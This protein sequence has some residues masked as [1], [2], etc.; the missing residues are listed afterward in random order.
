VHIEPTDLLGT[1]ALQS[2]WLYVVYG[3]VL[4]GLGA[5]VYWSPKW[6]GRHIGNAGAPVA[7]LG[8]L[9]TVA[10]S[11]PL[12]LAGLFDDES[13]TE[14]M[15]W[16]SAGGHALMVL[17]IL[18]TVALVLRRGERPG[19]DPWDGVTLEWATSSPA[20]YDNF[21]DVFTVTSAEP[22]LDMKNAQRSDA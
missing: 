12:L 21:S 4:G 16:V 6:S 9:A 5:L 3:G 8:F 11:L 2:A 20:P 17:T 1:P 15:W 10:A 19:D 13:F 22:L 7:L 18:A 14:I